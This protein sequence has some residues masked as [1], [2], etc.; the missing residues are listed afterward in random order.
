MEF[1]RWLNFNAIFT[2]LKLSCILR[3]ATFTDSKQ[4]LY[5][6]SKQ[7]IF[8]HCQ[9]SPVDE[10]EQSV[11]R[12]K[13]FGAENEK[14][15]ASVGHVIEFMNIMR[16]AVQWES[17]NDTDQGGI[18]ERVDIKF[19]TQAIE[20]VLNSMLVDDYRNNFRVRQGI[21]AAK[22]AI[23][24]TRT[25]ML[26]LRLIGSE[27]AEVVVDTL[28]KVHWAH[29]VGEKLVDRFEMWRNDWNES[30]IIEDIRKIKCARDKILKN[31][32]SIESKDV[33]ETVKE[34]D[35]SNIQKALNTLHERYNHF[36][37]RYGHVKQLHEKAKTYLKEL[38]VDLF[39]DFCKEAEQNVNAKL[40]AEFRNFQ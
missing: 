2:L 30:Q 33:N 7:P 3:N 34:F 10:I 1:P 21:T 27:R 29:F 19:G 37:T 23:M 5:S 31:P 18:G 24:R 26:K 38:H 13:E 17:E 20:E 11:K 9:L 16:G 12:L 15:L 4:E 6:P 40:T 8:A 39:E 32:Y 22:D 36:V 28:L 25:G 35:E 14:F